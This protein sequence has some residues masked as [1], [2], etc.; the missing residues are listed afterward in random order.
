MKKKLLAALLACAMVSS[1]AACGN[2][3]PAADTTKAPE[4]QETEAKPEVSE[5]IDVLTIGTTMEFKAPNRSDYNTGIIT[6]SLVNMTLATKDE[7]GNY[8]PALATEWKTDDALKWSFKMRDDVTW[9]DG[10]KVTA[11]DFKFTIEYQKEKSATATYTLGNVDSVEVTGDYSFDINLKEPN[12][13]ILEMFLTVLPK[14]IF[15]NVDDYE[16]YTGENALMGNGPYKVTNFDM[17]AKTVEFTARDDYFM[18]TP[19]V[20]KIIYKT[21]GTADT[22]YMALQ[23]EEIDMIYNYSKGVDASIIDTL[24]ADEKVK[25]K[26]VNNTGLPAGIYINTTVAPFDKVEMRKAIRAAIDYD[27]MAALFG[28]SLATAPAAGVLPEGSYGYKDHSK[29]SRNLDEAKSMLADLGYTDTNGDGIL[30]LDGKNLDFEITISSAKELMGRVAEIVKNN[31]AEA[32]INVIINSV[33]SATFSKIADVE[34]THVALLTGATPAG[35]NTNAGCGTAYYD[36]RY[37]AWSMVE[38]ETFQKIVDDML[39]A[40]SMDIYEKLAGD[41]QDWYVE[42]I[43]IIPLYNDVFV[44]AYSA[45]LDNLFYDGNY[46]LNNVYTMYEITRTE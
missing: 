22:M 11:E 24:M 6:R 32:G 2:K 26:V 8:L 19:H 41:V 21:Y 29:L 10:E 46:G 16:G 9:E 5:N 12:S 40:I 7:D 43:P 35:M 4:T 1:M 45:K 28:S 37:Y 31:L 42:N 15:E 38:D 13:R 17:D 33:D 27:Q 18:G 30:E 23:N 34:H 3:A 14:H 39:G 20:K 44:L 36:A 25:T